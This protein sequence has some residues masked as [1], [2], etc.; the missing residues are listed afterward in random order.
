MLCSILAC[1]FQ[2]K[3][4]A[5]TGFFSSIQ[6]SI[7]WLYWCKALNPDM[8]F[9]LCLKNPVDRV[10]DHWAWN[11]M[12][13]ADIMSDPLWSEVPGLQK[14]IELEMQQIPKGGNGTNFMVGVGASSYLRQSIY[15][16][17][18]EHLHKVFG[19]ES[20]M[21]VDFSELQEDP[22]SVSKAIYSFLEL[23][24]YRPQK[25]ERYGK[26]FP[27]YHSPQDEEALRPKLKEFFEGYNQKLFSY[28]GR[29]FDWN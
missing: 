16:P 13:V 6:P 29:D 25:L 21:I 5:K 23:P 19:K 20:V 10:F 26:S 7:S 4:F 3:G 17:F 28:L 22:L 18:I 12:I 14:S 2:E 11:Q 1:R 8:R 15:L 27:A 24:E 9:V